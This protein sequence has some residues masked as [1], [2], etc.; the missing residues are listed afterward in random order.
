MSVPRPP[1]GMGLTGVVAGG[2]AS[3]LFL[4]FFVAMGGR[5]QDYPAVALVDVSCG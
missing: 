3:L 4:P 2:F 1:L 5:P